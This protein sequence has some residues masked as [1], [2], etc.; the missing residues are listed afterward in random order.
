MIIYVFVG[1]PKNLT[2]YYQITWIFMNQYSFLCGTENEYIC[3]G[4]KQVD[5]IPH[6]SII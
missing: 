6:I 3:V 5:L 4:D 1:K 2:V